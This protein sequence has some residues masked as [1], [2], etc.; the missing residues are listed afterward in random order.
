MLIAN[1]SKSTYSRAF[2]WQVIYLLVFKHLLQFF[3]FW[4]DTLPLDAFDAWHDSIVS[5][6]SI[7]IP[8]LNLI[9]HTK[10]R[11]H[12][13][14]FLRFPLIPWLRQVPL[15]H[16]SFNARHCFCCIDAIQA[17]QAAFKK[18]LEAF[19]CSTLLRCDLFAKKVPGRTP[20]VSIS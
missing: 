2:S 20:H 11:M 4:K 12:V 19:F 3:P 17:V 14:L 5:T 10:R 16:G 18:R 13:F 7:C 15:F 1:L 9:G 6:L 8:F